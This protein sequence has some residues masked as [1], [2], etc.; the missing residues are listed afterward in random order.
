MFKV[1]LTNILKKR[2]GLEKFAS[3]MISSSML[4]LFTIALTKIPMNFPIMGTSYAVCKNFDQVDGFF[5]DHLDASNTIFVKNL[6]KIDGLLPKQVVQNDESKSLLLG[7]KHQDLKIMRQKILKKSLR[8]KSRYLQGGQKK[9]ILKK[10]WNASKRALK[11]LIV[12]KVIYFANPKVS[13]EYPVTSHRIYRKI[14]ISKCLGRKK[15]A[16]NKSHFFNYF[17]SVRNLIKGDY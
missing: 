10:K 5:P 7:K 17:D 16:S 6:D 4:V 13:A 14:K 12:P 3:T 11:Y 1:N 2:P 8:I 9:S 15:H